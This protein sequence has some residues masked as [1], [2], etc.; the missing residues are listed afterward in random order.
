MPHRGLTHSVL[1]PSAVRTTTGGG[2][3]SAVDVSGYANNGV[4]EFYAI[5]DIGAITGTQGTLD[6]T[7]E[8]CATTNG[9]F[10]TIATYTQATNTTGNQTKHVAI[11]QRY[12]RAVGTT[13][14]TSPSYNYGVYLVGQVRQA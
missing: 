11:T 14:G 8:Q 2:T 6:V 9:T 4:S 5:L 7:I 10:S 1:L 13:G 12:V 3:G